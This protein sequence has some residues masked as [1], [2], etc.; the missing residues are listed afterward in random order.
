MNIQ[1]AIDALIAQARA[2]L[3][4]MGSFDTLAKQD[5]WGN[6]KVHPAKAE[7]L[8]A[9]AG[10]GASYVVTKYVA[11][12]LAGSKARKSAYDLACVEPACV[13]GT[14]ADP[15]NDESITVSIT[16][17]VNAPRE[18]ADAA[19][20]LA[21]AVAGMYRFHTANKL[22]LDARVNGT[23]LTVRELGALARSAGVHV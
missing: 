12:A 18:S 16:G 7:R 10:L 19:D 4:I 1:E 21:H 13:A 23:K 8:R 6:G 11:A 2:L 9:E 3:G 20:A 5:A 22:N 17:D 15:R 14:N